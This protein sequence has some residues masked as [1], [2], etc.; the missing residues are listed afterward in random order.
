ML[1]LSTRAQESGWFSVS[2][3]AAMREKMA[4]RLSISNKPEGQRSA[5]HHQ[6]HEFP[7]HSLEYNVTTCIDA[8]EKWSCGFGLLLF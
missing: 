4:L 5:Q 8:T 1:S 6:P 3:F 2:S 7:L